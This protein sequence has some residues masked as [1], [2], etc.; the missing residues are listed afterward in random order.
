M[1]YAM[2]RFL[3][4]AAL[5]T[6]LPAAALEV[7]G[8][9]GARARYPENSLPAFEHALEVGADVLELDVAI[10]RDDVPVVTHDLYLNGLI[11]QGPKGE[12]V[13]KKGPRI[14]ELS[15]AELRGYDCG[16]KP[17]PDF[18]L[19]KRVPGAR[20]PTLDELFAFVKGSAR[21]DVRFNVETKIDAD[22]PEAAPAPQRFVELILNVV[23]EHKATDRVL[24]Q[25]FDRRTLE[26]ARTLEPELA[27]SMLSGGFFDRPLVWAR[28][29]H[30]QVISPRW[31]YSSWGMV[32]QAH[33][34]G[35]RVVPWTAN[36][37]SAWN[38]LIREGVDGII[39]DDPEAL[40]Q[41]LRKKGIR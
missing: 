36:T 39:T 24:L 37:P 4:I 22:D 20:I 10:T 3:A 30:P 40:I 23:R 12:A 15:L 19:Q 13:A 38:E 35:A 7:H 14:R 18:P 27:L 6:A 8:H 29:F 28:E 11:C 21:P 17:N 5:L 16:S 9:R 31:Q 1:Y 41:H 32:K 25:S 33:A 34:L 2:P 26:A